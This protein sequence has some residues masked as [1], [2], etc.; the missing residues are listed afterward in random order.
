MAR[1]KVPGSFIVGR[2]TLTASEVA[3]GRRWGWLDDHS[4][5]QIILAKLQQGGELSEAEKRWALALPEEILRGGLPDISAGSADESPE[6]AAVW[7]YLSVAWL[8]E[9][10]S[11]RR[12]LF[13]AIEQLYADFDY[14]EEVE[15]F[16]QYMPPPPGGRAGTPGMTERLESFL[17]AAGSFCGNR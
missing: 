17:R 6:V 13:D 16:V 12:Q 14:P 3:Y 1:F 10:V 5:V 7:V 11:V 8:C 2:V 4:T 15:G 9:N